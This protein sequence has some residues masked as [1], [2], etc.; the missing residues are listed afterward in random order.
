MIS[1]PIDEQTDG[2][3]SLSAPTKGWMP[4]SA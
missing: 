4:W 2:R 1:S 3:P